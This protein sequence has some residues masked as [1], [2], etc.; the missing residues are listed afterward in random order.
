M[1][2]Q[3]LELHGL[4]EPKSLALRFRKPVAGLEGLY[5]ITRTGRVWSNKKNDWMVDGFEVQMIVDGQKVFA[6]M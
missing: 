3:L 4:R 5:E 2:I 1:P 6:K